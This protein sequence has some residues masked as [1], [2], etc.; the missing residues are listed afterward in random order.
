MVWGWLPDKAEMSYKVFL[1]LV[2]EK[3]KQENI[4]FNQEEIIS[5]FELNIHKAIDSILPGVDI[6]GC[7]FHLA[8]AFKMKVDKGHMTKTYENDPEFKQFV[9]EATS[10]SHLPPDKLIDGLNYLKNNFNFE[11]EK[12]Q[13]FKTEFLKYIQEYWIEGCYPPKVWLNFQRSQDLTNNNQEG[14]NS[15]I[16]KELKQAN[17]SPG[18]LLCFIYK[19]LRGAE[20]QA[21]Q[22]SVGCPI[23]A[24]LRATK[25]ITQRR[26]RLKKNYESQR[27]MMGANQEKLL[28][29]YLADMSQN[30]S[31]AILKGNKNNPKVAQGNA[32]LIEKEGDMNTSSWNHLERT[33]PDLNE[34]EVDPFD[35]RQV[36]VSKRVQEREILREAQWWKGSKKCPS[37]AHGFIQRSSVLKCHVCNLY[38]HKKKQCM[39]MSEH[40]TPTCHKCK[41]M[42]KT[43]ENNGGKDFKCNVCEKEFDKKFNLQRHVTSHKEHQIQLIQPTPQ[44]IVVNKTQF[45]EDK[46]QEIPDIATMLKELQMESFVKAFQEEGVETLLLIRM[47]EEDLKEAFKECGVKRMGDRFKLTERLRVLKKVITEHVEPE[48]QETQKSQEES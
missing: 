35:G 47:Q 24:Q 22:S 38:T 31:S 1:A 28:A 19:Q 20:S 26:Y 46:R 27:R 8:K 4:P 9:R 13:K 12:V 34:I 11:D 37:C 40:N 3:L 48:S 42:S 7:F 43:H 41:P 18:L 17:P 32:P 30:V 10:L 45:V 21:A 15:R 36:G 2:I 16:N 44:D 23:P 39:T 25:L 14:M 33:L 5:D 29:T 6:L